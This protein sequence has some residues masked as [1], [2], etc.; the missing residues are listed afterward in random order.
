MSVEKKLIAKRGG[1]RAQATKLI[2]KI[3]D[4]LDGSRSIQL[5]T[6]FSNELERQRT[7]ISELDSEVQDTIDDETVLIDDISESSDRMMTIDT[8]LVVLQSNPSFI[9]EIPKVL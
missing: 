3:N 5:L 9:D 8:A 7:I 1:H 6:T 4:E 2:N